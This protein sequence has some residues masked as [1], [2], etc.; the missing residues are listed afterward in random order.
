[1]KSSTI[2][3][4][5]VPGAISFMCNFQQNGSVLRHSCPW[6]NAKFDWDCVLEVKNPTDLRRARAILRWN[7]AGIPRM[8]KAASIREVVG[9]EAGDAMW[10]AAIELRHTC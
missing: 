2:R 5:E 1:M 3:H 10:P 9:K 6:M 7:S 4:V 8:R